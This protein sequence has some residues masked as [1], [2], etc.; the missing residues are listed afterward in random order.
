MES[1]KPLPAISFL[2]VYLFVLLSASWMAWT[3][4]M[5]EING[6]WG[7][8]KDREMP[9]LFFTHENTLVTIFSAIHQ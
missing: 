9:T 3:A 4:E 7:I 8:N 1:Y 5:D 6:K 2:R